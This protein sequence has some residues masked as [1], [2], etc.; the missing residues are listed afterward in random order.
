MQKAGIDKTTIF[1]IIVVFAAFA[2]FFKIRQGIDVDSSVLSLLSADKSQKIIQDLTDNAADELSRKAF[3]LILDEDEENAIISAKKIMELS[4]ESEIFSEISSGTSKEIEKEYFKWFFERRYS[5]LSDNMREIVEDVNSSKKFI[6]YY[7]EKIFAPLPDFYGENLNLDPIMLFMDK[8]LE[9]NGNSQWISDGD[10]LIFPSDTTAILINVTLKESSFSP[11]VQNDLERLISLIESSV[12]SNLSVTGVARYAKKGFDEGKR[13]AGI[14]GAVSFTAVVILLF[15]VFRNILVIFAG[16][17]PIFCGLIFAFSA[18]VSLSPEINGIALSMGACFVGIVID[19]SLHYLT[20]NQTDPKKRLKAIFGGITLSVISTI[21]GFCAFFIT[22]VLGLRHIAIMSVFGLAGAYLSVVILFP[23]I[24]FANKKLPFELP[25]KSISQIPFSV[26]IIIAILISAIS[27]PG[28]LGVKYNDGVEN[29]RNPAPELEAQEAIL[30][31][32]T[33][34]TEANKFLAVVGKNN[35]DMLN[36]LSKISIRLNSLKNKRSIENYR[37]IG[38][39][40]NSAEN[41]DKNRKNLLKTLTQNDG[42][43]LKY[44]KGIGFKD[45]VL[46][47]LINE[48]SAKTYKKSDFDE[49]FNSPVSKNFKSTF[50]CGDSL[51][52]AL[53]LLDDIRDESEIKSLENKTSVFYFNRIDEITSVLQNYRK[54]MLKTIFIAALVIFSFLL[55]YFWISNGFL[56]AVS[57]IIPPF[58]TLVSTQAILGYL[59]VE[60]N[61][62][63]CV[64][65]L[66]VLG[67]GVD[68]SIFRAKSENRLN[69]TELAVLLS[70]I[71][72]FMAFGLLFFAKT[73]ALKSMGEIVAPGIVLS[74]L[75]SLLVKRK[76]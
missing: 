57:V 75:F 29:F 32:F 73:P 24:K 17:I 53:V 43:V 6:E 68:Y 4:Q 21:A 13:D 25:E 19:Y 51:S 56:S 2:I 10:F 31:K 49:F 42:E 67:I 66:L 71:T 20:Q 1:I 58:L 63:H 11:K 45:G 22:P 26:S 40:L 48:L 39:Y 27:I 60:Q 55:V 46:Q 70:C 44:L 52:A 72:S 16:L 59:G 37:S 69:E 15:S 36:E 30:R 33:G 7:N 3:F 5:L 47:N 14:I 65:Q 62:M 38:Q 35:D 50:V 54:T 8:M 74:Y 34:N 9:L 64:G 61:L 23:D 76:G 28:I 41:A 12:T 18:L